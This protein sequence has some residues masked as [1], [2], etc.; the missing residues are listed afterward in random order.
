MVGIGRR[1]LPSVDELAPQNW[2]LL[3][4]PVEELLDVELHP[5]FCTDLS[6]Y[7]IKASVFEA[8]EGPVVDSSKPSEL[9]AQN[10][11][12]SMGGCGR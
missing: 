1:A 6:G 7:R 12:Q 11:A 10:S 5:T 2:Y 4:A 9:A 3:A 8:K